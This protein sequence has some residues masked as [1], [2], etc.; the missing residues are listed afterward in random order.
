MVRRGW[1][2]IFILFLETLSFAQPPTKIILFKAYTQENT[3]NPNLVIAQRYTGK[4]LTRSLANPG[5]DDTWRCN[6][7]NVVLDPCFEDHNSL[8]CINSPWSPRVAMLELA[9]PLPKHTQTK[10]HVLL[11]H[12]PWGVELANGQRCTFLIGASSVINKMRLNYS[13]DLY[14][15]ILGDI[16]RRSPTWKALVYDFNKKTIQLMDIKAAYY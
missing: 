4:C 11:D 1:L 8:A 5:R 10:A 6:A 12:N 2:V 14:H 9:T 16:K 7:S 13:C 3:L 15:Y